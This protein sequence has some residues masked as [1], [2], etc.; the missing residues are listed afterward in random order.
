MG[1]GALRGQIARRRLIVSSMLLLCSFVGPTLND[2]KNFVW[3]IDWVSASLLPPD[4]IDIRHFDFH[5]L[6]PALSLEAIVVILGVAVVW[7]SICVGETWAWW[8]LCLAGLV[9]IGV[10]AWGSAFLHPEWLSEVA[11]PLAVWLGAVALAI[12]DCTFARCWTRDK[13]VA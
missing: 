7:R 1:L 8:A 10:K 5:A 3:Y 9:N 12:T 13:H 4:Q 2:L 11:L 6:A